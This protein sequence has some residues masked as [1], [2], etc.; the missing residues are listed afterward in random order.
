[1][2]SLASLAQPQLLNIYFIF[3]IFLAARASAAKTETPRRTKTPARGKTPRTIK[4]SVKKRTWADVAK[5]TPALKAKL[6]KP[7]AAHLQNQQR[8]RSGQ[9]LPT[10]R[11]VIFGYFLS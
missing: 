1:M 8:R 10:F 4:K 6:A 5:K 11:M 2:V 7:M 3:N 9:A